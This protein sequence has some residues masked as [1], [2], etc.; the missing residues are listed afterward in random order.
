MSWLTIVFYFDNYVCLDG[1]NKW[2]PTNNIRNT[3][4]A[5]IYHSTELHQI[6][7]GSTQLVPLT[8]LNLRNFLNSI[9]TTLLNSIKPP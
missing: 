5:L 2:H 8:V 9:K 1:F 3:F 7:I 4:L 6:Y